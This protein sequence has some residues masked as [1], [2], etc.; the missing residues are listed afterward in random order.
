[1]AATT[2]AIETMI[3]GV[4]GLIL[5]L[6]AAPPLY[7]LLVR[8]TRVLDASDRVRLTPIGNRLPASMRSAFGAV[9]EFATPALAQTASEPKSTTLS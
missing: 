2:Y 7:I 8:F 4:P 1:M 3:S 6:I 5:G 9:I